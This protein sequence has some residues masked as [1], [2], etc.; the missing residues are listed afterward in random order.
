[1][2]TDPFPRPRAGSPGGA[3]GLLPALAAAVVTASALVPWVLGFSA[4]HA[5]VAGSIAF[6][7][8][9]GPIALLV[10]AVPAAAATT[11]L[12]GAWLAASPWALGYAG[13]NAGA[14][15]ADVVAGLALMA[16][17]RIALRGGATTA[18]PG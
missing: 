9:F 11:A 1:M 7:M 12:A 10:N 15:V 4:S 17:A 8:T 2:T 16:I 3:A 14:W 13:L 6:A 18:A 5:A